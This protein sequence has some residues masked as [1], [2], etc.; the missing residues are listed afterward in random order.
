MR[1]EFIFYGG[2]R[3]FVRYHGSEAIVHGPAETGK[4][5]SALRKLDLCA[6]KY[7]R[8]SL[9]IARK[10]LTSAYSTVLQTYTE[11]V[12]NGRSDVAPYGGAKPEWFDYSNGSRIWI[13]GLDKMGKVLSAEHDIIYVNQAEEL[14]LSDWETL[15]TRTTGRAGNMPYAQTIG[16]ANPS[17]PTHWM[18]KRDSLRMFGSR[19]EDNPAL[20]D[21][22]TGKLT[23]QGARTMAVLD[24]LTG[25]RYQRLRLG[26]PAQAEGAIYTE[27]DEATHRIY[28]EDVPT[29]RR[30]IA[31]QDWGYTNPGV[32][33]VFG[34][35]YDGKMYLLRQVY[36]SRKTIDWWVE[37]ATQLQGVYGP[38]EA[39]VCDP[40]EPAYIAT[41]QQHGLRAVAAD[42]A[43]KP[44]ID[45][46]KQRLAHKRLFFVRDSL[47][48]VDEALLEGHTPQR[49]EDEFPAYVWAD[50]VNKEEPVKAD[51]HGVDMVRY[52]VMYVDG[53]NP[54]YAE[55]GANPLAGY[56][57]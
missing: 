5:I 26:L 16:D 41:Y 45:L 38:F 9:V 24:N 4:T 10:T 47:H 25:V 18:Y 13:A 22:R 48:D 30:Y 42:N 57:G 21:P 31:A 1:V 32:F 51:D 46:V 19:H 37:T 56:R 43:V 6:L 17:Y 14:D 52:A 53:I 40:S 28:A 15:T 54:A 7:P 34:L 3:D 2:A 23:E 55:W 8:A 35:D 50:K 20:Y 11:K 39:V 12:V 36:Q 33:A 29:P 44:G 49:V 27:W